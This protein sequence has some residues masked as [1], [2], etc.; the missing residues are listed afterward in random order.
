MEAVGENLDFNVKSI[1][2]QKLDFIFC[3]TACLYAHAQYCCLPLLRIFKYL[4]SPTSSA[5]RDQQHLP[6]PL[7][8]KVARTS[9]PPLNHVPITLLTCAL[10][11]AG[12]EQDEPCGKLGVV[13]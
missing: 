8:P 3:R 1:L 9:S 11:S 10:F 4:E 12:I 2:I 13:H 5:K 6:S 7:R